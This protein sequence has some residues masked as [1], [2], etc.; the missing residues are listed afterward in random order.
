MCVQIPT[1]NAG[2]F[3]VRLR[4]NGTSLTHRKNHSAALGGQKRGG[5][6]LPPVASTM[7]NES[8]TSLF[9]FHL[10][11]LDDGQRGNFHVDNAYL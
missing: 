7:I 10:W 5:I 8:C 11:S 3:A 2:G 1:T 4:K 9:S 6:S